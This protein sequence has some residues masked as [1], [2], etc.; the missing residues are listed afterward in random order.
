[1]QDLTVIGKN[2][3]AGLG[4]RASASVE[5]LRS[6]LQ[7][8]MAASQSAAAAPLVLTALATAEDK[9]HH[10]AFT[11]LAAEI[12][13]PV[14]AVPLAQLAE[15][16]RCIEACSATQHTAALRPP[17]HHGPQRYGARSLAESSAL[18][19]TGPGARLLAPRAVSTDRLATAAIAAIAE[20][21]PL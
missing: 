1:M 12:A 7:V 13:L 11:Q 8:A 19:A 3:V 2:T 9:A 10:P 5:S 4:F 21:T 14:V 15:L 17:H 6:A 20:S 16:A 18:S